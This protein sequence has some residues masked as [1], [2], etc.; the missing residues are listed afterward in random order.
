MTETA[1][2]WATQH[3]LHVYGQTES[4]PNPTTGWWE[5][6]ATG[7]VH[8]LCNCG[9]TTGWIPRDQ[10]PSREQMLDE[11]GSPGD[12]A[13]VD[14]VIDPDEQA[15][16]A[17]WLNDNGIDPRVVPLGRPITIERDADDG[18]QRIR[19]TA[20]RRSDTGSVYVDLSTG[21]AAMDERTT[22]LIVPPVGLALNGA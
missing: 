3:Q 20:L 9:Y 8:L 15:A 1:Q 11:H 13:T 6:R 4:R 22:P 14:A 2:P 18:Q 5:R 7:L 19:Y 16:L 21:N 12:T 10:M 17:E